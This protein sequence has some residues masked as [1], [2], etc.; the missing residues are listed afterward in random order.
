MLIAVLCSEALTEHYTFPL[1]A[2]Q[3]PLVQ[4]KSH[5]MIW[6]QNTFLAYIPQYMLQ[7][8]TDISYHRSVTEKWC[9]NATG[10]LLNSFKYASSLIDVNEMNK[11]RQK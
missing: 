3:V 10:I 9:S 6:A 5:F 4:N 8:F 2:L 1:P 7:L 11:S